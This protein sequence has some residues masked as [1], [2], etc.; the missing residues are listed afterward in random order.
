MMRRVVIALA[1]AACAAGAG[2]Q[3]ASVQQ[4][5]ADFRQMLAA[6]Q[7]QRR[8]YTW[9]ETT[10]IAYQGE[11]KTTKISDCQY[12]GPN[13]Q[14]QCTELSLQ[15]APLP[16]GFFR[17]RIAEQKANELKAYMDSVRTLVLQYV[18]LHPALIDDAYGHGNVAVAQNPTN[19]TTRLIIS[20]Y[21]QPG[22]KVTITVNS[23]TKRPQHVTIATWLNTPTAV[24]TLDVSFNSFANG[25]FYAYQKVVNVK[26]QSVTVTITSSDFSEMVAQ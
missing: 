17:R 1:L 7:Q 16:G 2:A 22:D 18:P 10:Q 19:G 15:Q 14:P 25:V 8:Q 4:R 13:P 21:R 11:V 6:N 20:N 23:V 12:V 5:V 3:Q 26:S 9:L 24:V